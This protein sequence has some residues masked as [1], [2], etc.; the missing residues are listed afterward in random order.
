M[1]GDLL[2]AL[3]SLGEALVWPRSSVSRLDFCGGLYY[4]AWIICVILP[5]AEVSE[6]CCFSFHVSR[7]RLDGL[8]VYL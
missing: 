2:A 5:R 7:G 8:F 3:L 6:L 1:A 4:F